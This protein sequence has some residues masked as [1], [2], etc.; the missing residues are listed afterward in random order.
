MLVKSLSQDNALI[1][2]ILSLINSILHQTFTLKINQIFFILG[3]SISTSINRQNHL[4]LTSI[5]LVQSPTSTSPKYISRMY[6]IFLLIVC[7]HDRIS[8]A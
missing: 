2:K 6:V 4:C 8:G 3:Y 7:T 1:H 5:S